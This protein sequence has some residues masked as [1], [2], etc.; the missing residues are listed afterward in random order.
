MQ[1]YRW[2]EKLFFTVDKTYS[3]YQFCSDKYNF[4]TT[5]PNKQTFEDFGDGSMAK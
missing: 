5:G 4:S 2:T 3:Y 1:E